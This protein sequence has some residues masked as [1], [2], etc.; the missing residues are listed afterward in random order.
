MLL[1][2][3][4]LIKIILLILILTACPSQ[5]H[6]V[7][8]EHMPVVIEW[9]AGKQ[10]TNAFIH[11][12][13][14]LGSLIHLTCMS[15][16][17]GENPRN[18]GENMQISYR[19]EWNFCIDMK[20]YEKIDYRFHIKWSNIFLYLSQN[21]NKLSWKESQHILVKTFWGSLSFTCV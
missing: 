13:S 6:G 15:L 5:D 3:V 7:V 10:R 11:I 2:F 12:E 18:H 8:L 14:N 21:R 16:N 4:I 19:K 17:C 1:C 20:N 9:K